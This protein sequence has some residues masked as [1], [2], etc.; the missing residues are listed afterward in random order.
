MI[1]GVFF[2]IKKNALQRMERQ[3]WYEHIFSY[4]FMCDTIE[5]CYTN[6][7]YHGHDTTN[8]IFLINI[9]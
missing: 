1:I 3:F 8:I 5:K 9:L 7:F 2:I 6:P 4:L